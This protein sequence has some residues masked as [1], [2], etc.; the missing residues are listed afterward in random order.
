[1]VVN[2]LVDVYDNNSSKDPISASIK[3]LL[4]VIIRILYKW[5]NPELVPTKI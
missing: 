1:M 4:V 5:I 2:W 3:L